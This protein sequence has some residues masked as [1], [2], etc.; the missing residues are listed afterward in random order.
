MVLKFNPASFSFASPKVGSTIAA[1]ELGTRAFPN[2]PDGYTPQN[3]TCPSTRPTVR[4]ASALSDNETSWL[5]MR[6]NNTIAPMQDLLGRLNISGFDAEAYITKN[7]KN[8]S[9]LPNIAIAV[10]GGGYRACLNG[11]GAVQAFDSREINSTAAGHLGGLL[12]SATYLAGLSG[13]GWLV[14]SIFVNNFT[15]I[16]ALL[17]NNASSVWDFG[18]SIIE[19]PATGSIQVLDS[20][21]YYTGIEHEVSAKGDAGFNT[22]VTDYWGRALSFQLVNASDG[23]ASYTWSSI[24]LQ[25]SFAN[26]NSPMPILVSDGR[27]PGETLIP[28]NTTIYEF[29]PFEFGTWDPTTY[30]FVPL[31]FLGSNFSGGVL[32]DS[33]KCVRGFDNV[34]YVMGTSSS[35]FNQLILDVNETSIPQLAKSFVSDILSRFS[36]A[37]NDI[38]QYQ[39]NPFYGYHKDT[40]IV[41]QESAL[42]LVDGGEDLENIPLHPLIQPFRHLD[43]I[44]AVDSSADTNNWPNGTSLVATY[45]RS[46]NGTSADGGNLANGTSFPAIPDQNTFVNLGLNTRPTFFGCN[47]SNTSSP[48]PLV[49][50]IP[51]FPYTYQSNVSTFDLSYNTSQR[52]LIVENGYNVATMGNGTANSTWPVC[53]GCAI[54][55]R[56]LERT[57]TTLP[58]ACTQCFADFCWDGTVNSTNP[59]NYEPTYKINNPGK[60]SAAIREVASYSIA[61]IV[62]TAVLAMVW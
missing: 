32:A 62:A 6:R 13:G 40:S 50:Y 26:A 24:Q 48:T 29:N 3:T 59:A 42:S 52:D 19:G 8:A 60:K 18:N 36:G 43:V 45:Q 46:L 25:E 7:A 61:A 9:A 23:G 53:V 15:T 14:G 30:G 17:D 22:S 54:L 49:V 1:A 55:Q 38:A 4:S 16:T 28:G 34:G 27:A 12:Q 51:N 31:E 10:S 47:S 20:A 35:L 11:G 57:Q 5:E 41:Y 2:A 44:F 58:Q 21:E 33:E 39:P 37:D 56:S